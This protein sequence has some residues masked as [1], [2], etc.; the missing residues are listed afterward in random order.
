MTRLLATDESGRLKKELEESRREAKELQKRANDGLTTLDTSKKEL[1]QEMAR[2]AEL[3][4]ELKLQQ[5]ESASRLEQREQESA[6]KLEQQEREVK[7]LKQE[8]ATANGQMTR[9]LATDESGRLK[10][11][12][13]LRQQLALRQQLETEKLGQSEELR[14]QLET[15]VA[16]GQQQMVRIAELELELKLEQAVRQPVKLL[17]DSSSEVAKIAEH[18]P[19]RQKANLDQARLRQDAALREIF[20]RVD[21]DS[22]GHIDFMELRDLG[23][24]P[25]LFI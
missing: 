6:L 12:L 21:V 15:A 9:L 18:E 16:T 5:Q 20:Q 11:E 3:K 4:R 19:R 23:Q 22:S 25:N 14:R 24:V 7:K 2:V 1:R 17:P 10:K 8:L 13:E